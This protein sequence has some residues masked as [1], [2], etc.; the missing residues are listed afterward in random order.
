MNERFFKKSSLSLFLSFLSFFVTS[1]FI[2]SGWVHG[3]IKKKPSQLQEGREDPFSLPPGVRLHSQEVPVSKENKLTFT[4]E[5]KPVE[6]PLTLKAI[7]ITDHV[8]LASIDRSVVTVGDFINGEKVLEIKP[9]RVILEKEG[10]KRTVLLEQSPVK[11]TV[12]EK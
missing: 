9:D 2:D 5:I 6:V 8:R 1:L 11:L 3:Q 12:E 7:L 10:K 4:P